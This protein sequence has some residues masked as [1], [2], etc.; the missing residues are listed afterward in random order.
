[1]PDRLRAAL[2]LAGRLA[3][4]TKTP[5]AFSQLSVRLDSFMRV[6]LQVLRT[7]LPGRAWLWYLFRLVRMQSQRSLSLRVALA[8][9]IHF[10]MEGHSSSMELNGYT[11]ISEDMNH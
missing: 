10:C 9:P 3:I 8:F 5:L 2:L 4:P 11:I 7:S 1:M 6:P